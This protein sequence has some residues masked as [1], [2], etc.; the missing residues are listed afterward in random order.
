[1]IAKSICAFRIV[2]VIMGVIIRVVFFGGFSSS[3]YVNLDN[4]VKS[5]PKKHYLN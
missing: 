1:M 4:L 2:V 5:I 3:I